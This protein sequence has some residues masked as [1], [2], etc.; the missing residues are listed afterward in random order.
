MIWIS[1]GPPERKVARIDQRKLDLHV[2]LFI[3]DY[4]ILVE[5]RFTQVKDLKL[6]NPNPWLTCRR[7]VLGSSDEKPR[8]TVGG[9][10]DR[11]FGLLHLL[12]SDRKYISLPT[13]PRAFICPPGIRTRWPTP[14]MAAV[15]V[16]HRWVQPTGACDGN[17][18]RSIWGEKDRC[19]LLRFRMAASS[20][21]A[22]GEKYWRR[23]RW[24]V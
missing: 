3:F 4:L 15:G 5:M 6:A 1:E 10:A 12:R 24:T 21:A 19:K 7:S 18:G 2:D 23:R 9:F 8:H 11:S 14:G 16:A 17:I 13:Y 20:Y 22:L